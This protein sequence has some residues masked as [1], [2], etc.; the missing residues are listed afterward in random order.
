MGVIPICGQ[1]NAACLDCRDYF[2][3]NL[4]G[5][6]DRFSYQLFQYKGRKIAVETVSGTIEYGILLEFGIDYIKIKA[7]HDPV[8]LMM[9]QHI[10]S[11]RLLQKTNE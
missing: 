6:T 4:A 10:Q 11:I 9:R 5:L 1:N 7:S 2:T 3:L 8:H